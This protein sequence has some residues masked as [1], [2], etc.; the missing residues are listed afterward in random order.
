MYLS[1]K[2]E[3][4]QVLQTSTLMTVSIQIIVVV[5]LTRVFSVILEL[6][7]VTSIT[8][9]SRL[10]TTLVTTLVHVIWSLHQCT[11]PIVGLVIRR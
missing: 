10:T 8:T 4:K 1:Y 6:V 5:T 11:R 3:N 9:V 7:V 2:Y